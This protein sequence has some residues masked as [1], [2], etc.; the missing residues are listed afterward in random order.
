[1][2]GRELAAGESEVVAGTFKVVVPFIS[3]NLNFD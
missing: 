1:M 3:L 2:M